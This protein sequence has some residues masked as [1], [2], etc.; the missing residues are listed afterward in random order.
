MIVSQMLII[1][2]FMQGPSHPNDIID[3]IRSYLAEPEYLPMILINLPFPLEIIYPILRN[4]CELSHIHTYSL[5][6]IM[7]QPTPSPSSPLPKTMRIWQ[8]TTTTSG[9]ENTLRLNPSSPLPTPKKPTQHLVQILATALN[10]V[11]YKPAEIPYV[12]RLLVPRLAT[13]CID[14]AGRIITPATATGDS[15]PPLKPGQLIFGGCGTSVIAGGALAEYA[16]VEQEN[17]VALPDG[18]DPLD[19]ATLAV[20]GLTAYQ[21]IV[22]RV[23]RGDRVFINGGSGGTGTFG[24]QFAKAVGCHVTATCSTGNVEL[25]RSLGADEV[26]DYKKVGEKGVVEAL[27][28]LSVGAD[29][30]KRLFDH[31]VDNVSTDKEL[32]WRAHE[33]LKPGAAYVLVGGS[34]AFSFVTD[35]LKRKLLPG[36]LGGIKAKVEGF[37]PD[38]RPEDLLQIAKWIKDGKVR[39][40]IDQKFGFEEAP[41]AFEKLKTGR[42]RGKIVV[43]VAL[44]TL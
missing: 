38:T 14:F 17:A 12:G 15:A 16:I 26:V 28:A 33:F 4:T 20:A 9:L 25:C 19:A 11:D 31:A 24:I 13:P 2:S 34:P 41:R 30:Q 22:P 23:K 42:A 21:S 40:V 27:K 43:D 37:W 18:I 35:L 1:T 39:T 29:G 8:Y 36:F 6:Y 5:P 32:Y 10:P 44:G 3:A 7:A